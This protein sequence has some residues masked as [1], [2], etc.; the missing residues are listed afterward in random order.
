VRFD[1][2]RIDLGYTFVGDTIVN[3]TTELDGQL[4][5]TIAANLETVIAKAVDI[6]VG[7]QVFDAGA[8]GSASVDF[9]PS[10]EFDV[11]V[12]GFGYA[13]R[14][15]YRTALTKHNDYGLDVSA[16]YWITPR[17]RLLASYQLSGTTILGGED[18]TTSQLN[19][20]L[21][22]SLRLRLP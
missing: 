8:G 6:N 10:K 7:A 3:P 20:A 14:K 17:V 1:N 13:G 12:G 5:G 2:T 4:W 18:D 22:A 21:L 15:F 11:A 19:N 16:G 9:Y